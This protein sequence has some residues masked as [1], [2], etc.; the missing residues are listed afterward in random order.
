MLSFKEPPRSETVLQTYLPPTRNQKPPKFGRA[1][2]LRASQAE[3]FHSLSQHGIEI[4][5]SL[6]EPKS[7]ENEEHRSPKIFKKYTATRDPKP[8]KFEMAAALRERR[9]SH[10]ENVILTYPEHKIL[11]RRSLEGLK[12]SENDELCMPKSFTKSSP[13]PEREIKSWSL[14][15]TTN[16][17]NPKDFT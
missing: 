4:R 13:P 8:P 12:S 10:P 6:K 9:A 2:A 11:S 3:K 7:S 5:L 16:I 17:V 15:R 1:E 14:P